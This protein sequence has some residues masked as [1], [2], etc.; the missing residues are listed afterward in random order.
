VACA[1]KEPLY[2]LKLQVFEASGAQGRFISLFCLFVLKLFH[3]VG[4]NV[5]STRVLD[6]KHP[7]FTEEDKLLGRAARGSLS[8]SSP[9]LGSGLSCGCS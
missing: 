5:L 6:W 4:F 9:F 1:S 2:Y 3:C 7:R 8:L